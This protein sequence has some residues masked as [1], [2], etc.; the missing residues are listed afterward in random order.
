[1]PGQ[2]DELI[3][4]QDSGTSTVSL[5]ASFSVVGFTVKLPAGKW[6]VKVEKQGYLNYTVEQF[7]IDPQANNVIYFGD[8]AC[9]KGLAA[10]EASKVVPIP[11]I[12][13][14][15]NGEGIAIAFNDAAV[16]VAG[17]INGALD[18]NK[19]KGDINESN[20]SSGGASDVSDM[21]LVLQNMSKGRETVDYVSGFCALGAST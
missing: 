4:T 19:R 8:A 21:S 16:V 17:W 13:G 12:P 20:L 10:G 15:A 5:D 3:L 14:D 6:T 11:M 18:I 1:M 2:T 9:N 7:E